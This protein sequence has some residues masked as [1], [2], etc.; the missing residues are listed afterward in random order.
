ML[1]WYSG[2]EPFTAGWLW[3][4][5]QEA[6]LPIPRLAD[7][8]Q[9]GRLP[10]S[11]LIDMGLWRTFHSL[12]LTQVLSVLL[13]AASAA[14]LIAS[15]KRVRGTT[16]NRDAAI[17]LLLMSFGNYEVVSIGYYMH[18][19]L[20][21]FL[22]SAFLA[23][24]NLAKN[25]GKPAAFMA[26]IAVFLLPL[27][28]PVGESVT[29]PLAVWVVAFGIYHVRRDVPGKFWP[30]AIIITGISGLAIFAAYFVGYR[31]PEYVPP[32]PGVAAI[33][34]TVMQFISMSLGTLGKNTMFICIPVFLFLAYSSIHSLSINWRGYK[35][36]RWR[37]AGIGAFI[38]SLAL[39]SG[40]IGWARAGWS[41]DAGLRHRYT[42]IS[43]PIILAAILSMEF[44]VAAPGIVMARKIPVIL[45]SAA[46]LISIKPGIDFGSMRRDMFN[47]V[48]ADIISG[49]TPREIASSWWPNFY[50]GEPGTAA[51]LELM[52]S[53]KIGPYKNLPASTTTLPI[54]T[55]EWTTALAFSPDSK[56]LATGTRNGGIYLFNTKGL[57]GPP[58]LTQGG[59]V[60]SI[61]FLSRGKSAISSG[62]DGLLNI[63]AVSGDTISL[64]DRHD[65]SERMRIA[66]S[67]VGNLLA[68]GRDDGLI[69]LMDPGS[70]K[71][72]F[73]LPGH[74]GEIRTMAFTLDGALLASAGW[75]RLIR[76]WNT[77]TGRSIAVLR[78]HND[79]VCAS[80]FSPDGGTLATASFDGTCRTWDTKTWKQSMEFTGG[81]KKPCFAAY[82]PDCTV[83]A[84]G[85]PDGIVTFW[86]MASRR[87][88]SSFHAHTD[89]ITCLIFSPDGKLLATGSRQG[90]ARIWVVK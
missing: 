30:A 72:I 58:A 68:L 36:N 42:T 44:P 39:M 74:D 86:D 49:K 50:Y 63:W 75:D 6:R 64:T 22:M 16:Q 84:V 79:V 15:I 71:E 17:P 76:V 26:A 48:R 31:P 18:F 33:I 59:E 61:A 89:A 24:V 73:A 77:S 80:A 87:I 23:S 12:L 90:P 28:G 13:L 56:T 5:D 7:A 40:F 57:P 45:A 78:G 51:G 53:G 55:G 19:A 60:S 1:P 38:A 69:R 4:Q 3:E 27:S 88:K 35:H 14:I 67:P 52:R 46:Y 70:M 41:D 10:I 43:A 82:S 29:V 83:L 32:P 65:R 9:E 11:R 37:I 54:N 25:A 34:R 20:S 85:E 21:V 8:G 81:W 47:S 62:W 2:I 66:I